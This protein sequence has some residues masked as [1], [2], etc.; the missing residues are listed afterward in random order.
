MEFSKKM[1]L[2]HI[3]ISVCLCIATGVG[4]FKGV[5]VTALGALAGTSL[6][7]DGTWGGLYCWKSKNENRA[8]Y[9]QKFVRIIAKEYGIDAAIRIS[10]VVLK[11]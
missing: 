1:L 6:V 5:D 4:C 9:A 7:A 3:F 2:L 10:E 8:K 11:D